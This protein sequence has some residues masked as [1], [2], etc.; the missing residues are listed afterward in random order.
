M[1]G[2]R[3]GIGVVA[4]LALLAT[5]T[6]A[7]A[8]QCA[9]VDEVAVKA[10]GV[11]CA[12]AR[13]VIRRHLAGKELAR[14]RCE[15]G[16]RRIVCRNRRQRGRAVGRLAGGVSGGGG[17]E[18]GGGEAGTG[19]GGAVATGPPEAAFGVD[20]A[21]GPAPVVAEFNDSSS[22]AIES[23]RWQFGDGSPDSG[24]PNPVHAFRRPGS[25][26]VRLTV[27]GP[28]GAS[29]ASRTIEAG[30]ELD[31]IPPQGGV[32]E[33]VAYCPL[34]HRLPDDPIIYPSMPGASHLHD[35]FGNT[36]T[37]AFSTYETLLGGATNCDPLPDRSPYWVPSLIDPGGQRIA[38]EQAT[39]YYLSGH[40]DRQDVRAFPRGLRVVAGDSKATAP[41][42]TRVVQWGC[43]GVN[44]PASSEMVTCPE[45]SRL[46][47]YVDFPDCWNGRDRDSAD[48]QS[49]MAY[50][51]GGECPAGHPIAVPR[52][53][54]KLRYPVRGGP[55]F[56]LSSGDPITAHG[57]FLNAW[58]QGELVRRVEDCLHPRVK[59]DPAGNVIG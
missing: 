55:G 48:H 11:G 59:C 53:Q 21:S 54:F 8:R 9:K 46:E 51:N 29:T 26:E 2:A 34:S 49:H 27:R 6:P 23:W 3:E 20:R 57:D 41:Q 38:T 22:G 33:F 40:D 37:D 19:P 17:S 44:L 45:G 30:P 32:A 43:L 36:G 25:Y 28:E 15:R 5:T 16:E 7:S 1:R 4:S 24:E 10:R 18:G 12:K 14:W 47:L 58:D 39:F 13:G 35:F 31:P 50:S 42:S 52:L 56:A